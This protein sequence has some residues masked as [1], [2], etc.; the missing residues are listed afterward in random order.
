MAYEAMRLQAAR[1]ASKEGA[2]LAIGY[3]QDDGE[4]VPGYCPLLACGPAFVID[5]RE[6]A[7]PSGQVRTATREEKALPGPIAA[8]LLAQYR[9][10]VL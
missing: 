7:L 4:L 9:V 2:T 5:V 1:I 8:R 3:Q 10:E 6:V